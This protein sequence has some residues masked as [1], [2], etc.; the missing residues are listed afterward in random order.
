MKR[1]NAYVSPLSPSLP[2]E[3]EVFPCDFFQILD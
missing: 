2:E 3:R 1:N